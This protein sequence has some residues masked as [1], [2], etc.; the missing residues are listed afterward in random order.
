MASLVI[1]VVTS[2]LLLGAGSAAAQAPAASAPKEKVATFLECGRLAWIKNCE[3]LDRAHSEN[4]DA[5]W[6]LKDPKG[7]EFFFAPDT[8]SAMIYHMLSPSKESARALVDYYAAVNARAELAAKFSREVLLEKYGKDHAFLTPSRPPA[9][10]LGGP[11]KTSAPRASSP[12]RPGAG[13]AIASK[14][15][16][17]DYKTL[18]VWMF[19]DSK[20]GP[21]QQMIPEI[22][23]LTRRHPSLDVTLLQM[24]DDPGYIAELRKDMGLKAGPLPDK[25]RAAFE[26]RVQSTPTIWIQY[27]KDRKTAVL[28][29]F[30]GFNE[31]ELQMQ[32]LNR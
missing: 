15:P 13:S 9:P 24:N 11:G 10:S 29:G 3:D 1:R 18:R 27:G 2:A 31:I 14:P 17:L 12:S 19:Y 25:D 23:A 16:A 32:E 28:E 30:V 21:C 7:L 4:P 22:Y 26:A 5:P 6:R 20:C 8:P